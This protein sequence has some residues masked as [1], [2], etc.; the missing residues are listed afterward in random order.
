MDLENRSEF[1]NTPNFD[2]NLENRLERL[3]RLV[4]LLKLYHN[5]K[6]LELMNDNRVDRDGQELQ[7]HPQ[8]QQS[9]EHQRVTGHR[10]I[11]RLANQLGEFLQRI[12]I[13]EA[14][15]HLNLLE[16]RDAG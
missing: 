4:Q 14:G 6:S 2:S 7:Q 5:S 16:K 8:K 1:I 12:P 10:H 3:Q 9:Q 15:D 11:R 13:S